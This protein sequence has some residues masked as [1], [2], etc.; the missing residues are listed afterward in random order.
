MDSDIRALLRALPT[1]A[2]IETL[3]LRIET[4]RRY[5]QA[6][7]SD[8]QALSVRL[9]TGESSVSALETRVSALESSLADCMDASIS[10]QLHLEDLEDRSRWSNL[11][12][13]RR[14]EAMGSEDLRDSV[15]AI[16]HKVLS[17]S[18]PEDIELDRV[19]WTLGPRSPDADRPRDV[20]CRVHHYTQ[21]E[22]ILRRA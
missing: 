17:T 18:L 16:F 1:R 5:L 13:R 10:L 21:K 3:I 11:R 22:T 7:K 12:L 8:V 14:S 19:H 15:T 9:H 2:E 6:V 4:H 20:V